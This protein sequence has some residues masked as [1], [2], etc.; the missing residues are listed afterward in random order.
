V[1][2][3]ASLPDQSFVGLASYLFK[4]AV[5]EFIIQDSLTLDNIF[6]WTASFVTNT[7][8]KST[9]LPSSE[10]WNKSILQNSNLQVAGI[11][12]HVKF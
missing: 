12:F 7:G 6:G 4:Q 10:R 5:A 11:Y 1:R 9:K 2:A 8:S 3:K